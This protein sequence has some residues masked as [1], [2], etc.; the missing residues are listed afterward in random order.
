MKSWLSFLIGFLLV[1][2]TDYKHDAETRFIYANHTFNIPANPAVIAW[3][4]SNDNMLIF[5]YGS[6]QGKRYLTFSDLTQD[7]SI[8]HNCSHASF[9]AAVFSDASHPECNQDEITAF[10]A[11]FT[12]EHHTGIWNIDKTTVYFSIANGNAFLFIVDGFGTLIKVDS[13]FLTQAQL[14]RIIGLAQSD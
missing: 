12:N 6:L 2:C 10:R 11:I 1:G 14:K 4:G 3:T 9:F 13:D 8:Q 5:R 7:K